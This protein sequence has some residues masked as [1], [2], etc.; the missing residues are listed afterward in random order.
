MTCAKERDCKDRVSESKTAGEKFIEV[1]SVGFCNAGAAGI[2]SGGHTGKCDMC[3]RIQARAIDAYLASVQPEP[4]RC[5][6]GSITMDKHFEALTRLDRT[7]QGLTK[8]LKEKLAELEKP[9]PVG[10]SEFRKAMRVWLANFI[11]NA[12]TRPWDA[13]VKDNEQFVSAGT[14]LFNTALGLAEAVV[15][16]CNP[17]HKDY[18]G[19]Q[20][21]ALREPEGD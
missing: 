15:Q 7:W 20:I 10:E 11:S 13:I 17:P 14:V 6:A 4:E 1:G 8:D 18:I 12:D 19:S 3:K 9:A 16:R 21:A 2:C 5:E